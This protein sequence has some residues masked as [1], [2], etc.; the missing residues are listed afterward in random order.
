MI[1]MSRTQ[2]LPLVFIFLLDT[3]DHD[4][5]WIGFVWMWQ[6]I[7]GKKFAN[8]SAFGP[9]FG[10]K[11]SK[12]VGCCSYSLG[13]P[14]HT[15]K[16]GDVRLTI[17]PEQLHS[18][19]SAAVGCF[20]GFEVKPCHSTAPRHWGSSKLSLLS[21]CDV[22]AAHGTDTQTRTYTHTRADRQ[23]QRYITINHD[24]ALVPKKSPSGE[25]KKEQRW[26]W[27]QKEEMKAETL[28]NELEYKSCVCLC[29]FTGGERAWEEVTKEERRCKI[30]ELQLSELEVLTHEWRL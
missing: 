28:G 21:V 11:Q 1:S 13:T 27:W 24:M 14:L 15:L 6:G 4:L 12:F 25:K 26:E 23:K 8:S 16:H 7:K 2:D 5:W 17:G 10:P 20:C 22:I 18:A 30:G 9:N 29:A 3:T 19:L